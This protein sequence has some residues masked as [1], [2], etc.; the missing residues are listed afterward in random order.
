MLKRLASTGINITVL[1]IAIGIFAVAFFALSAIGEASKPP[2]ID[3]LAAARDISIGDPIL[4][5]DIITRSVF[6]D[7]NA[8]LYIPADEIDSVIGGTAALPIR[9]N[10]P[11]F[12]DTILAKAAESERLAA[13]LSDYPG[14]SLF[15]LPLDN[16]NI[17]AP[18]IESFLP[19]DLINITFVIGYRPQEQ[20]T[21]T[22]VAP[23]A[24]GFA[25]DVQA[26][27]SPDEIAAEEQEKLTYPP[28]SK[29][30][31]PQGVRVVSIQ[32]VPANEV[33]TDPSTGSTTVS[34][35]ASS[36]AA[37]DQPKLLILLVPNASREILSL[38]LDQ[39]DLVAVSLLARGEDGPTKGFT[40]W[41]LEEWFKADRA[42]INGGE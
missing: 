34:Q 4:P 22:P 41:D 1:I 14:Y 17:L 15:P 18:A 29:D 26:T 40:Y 38:A 13:L 24:G 2:K 12:R 30:I 28:L 3:V 25:Q 6:V 33:S 27:P 16:Q 7:D 23:V 42:K 20:K 5:G 9:A 36:A 32:G 10:H 11:I 8:A 31:F 19:G 21:E 35:P 39:G 37:L